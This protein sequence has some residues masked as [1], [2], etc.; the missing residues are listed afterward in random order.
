MLPQPFRMLA[1]I[2]E[3]DILDRAWGAITSSITYKLLQGQLNADLREK[4]AKALL[5]PPNAVARLD[6]TVPTLPSPVRVSGDRDMI[7][8]LHGYTSL[9]LLQ[10][11]GTQTMAPTTPLF[12]SPRLQVHCLSAL[13]PIRLGLIKRT[14]FS[15]AAW[16]VPKPSPPPPIDGV[17]A[18][19]DVP[20]PAMDA[21]ESLVHMYATDG[22]TTT[23][24]CT[25][26]SMD[27]VVGLV[28][29]DDVSHMAVQ[30]ESGMV[31]VY[32]TAGATAD[33]ESGNVLMLDASHLA[34][35]VDPA[36]YGIHPPTKST[37]QEVATAPVPAKPDKHKDR[38]GA[39]GGKD[40]AVEE[41][42]VAV[43]PSAVYASY[44]FLAFLVDASSRQPPTTPPTTTGIVLASQ[45]KT[46]QYRLEA[47]PSAL[48]PPN[49][50]ST[51][52]VLSS[53][54]TCAA[55]DASAT[56]LVLGLES[57]S[58]VA[59][60]TRLHV[61]HSGLGCHSAPV[62][63]LALFKTDCLVSL[64]KGNQVHFYSLRGDGPSCGGNAS[65]KSLVRVRTGEPGTPPYTSVA[66]LADVPLTILGHA[67]GTF[68]VVD[69]RTGDVIGSLSLDDQRPDFPFD[70]LSGVHPFVIGDVVY[71]PTTHD[72]HVADDSVRTIQ[73]NSFSS[74]SILS[75]CFPR[76]AWSSPS[77][78]LDK[79]APVSTPAAPTATSKPTPSP[80]SKA[81]L[82]PTSHLARTRQPSV[83]GSATLLLGREGSTTPSTAL[84]VSCSL[85]AAVPP[86]AKSLHS[87][88]MRVLQKHQSV[89]AERDARLAK[90]RA[91]VL[92]A[93]NS[94]W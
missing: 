5:S 27:R 42:P 13:I 89:A 86:P 69:C 87:I 6:I 11:N 23:L 32:R 82:P 44:L 49:C 21:L 79:V 73:L 12:P 77:N 36:S 65:H 38:G 67:D 90:R 14:F 88:Y 50:A 64:S 20:D 10:S 52:V 71:V 76:S 26:A 31:E 45:F 39:K 24:R 47:S 3:N 83:H 62:V 84:P 81:G 46:L 60:D 30:F 59:W 9:E 19:P 37:M 1:K 75:T 22:A 91:D 63:A 48:T 80:P 55:L 28:L 68:T 2:L 18:Q 17:P 94:M 40:H 41:A 93:L 33:I 53:T 56:L 34:L 51:S 35:H 29:A 74:T 54:V 92:K 43:A 72:K 8:I 15:V 78:F 7:G 85:N 4:E 61:E 16:K 58:V 66:T 70:S 25:L 57:G